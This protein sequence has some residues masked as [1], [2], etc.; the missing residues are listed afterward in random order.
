MKSKLN[1][2][3]CKNKLHIVGVQVNVTTCDPF[4]RVASK[5]PSELRARLRCLVEAKKLE[6][7]L[8]DERR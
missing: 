1:Q 3:V 5:P 7:L 8:D 4:A 2:V 6:K